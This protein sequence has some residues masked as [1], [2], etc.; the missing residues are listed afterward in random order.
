MSSLEAE[1]SQTT[2]KAILLLT[3]PGNLRNPETRAA[4][5]KG[6]AAGRE[7]NKGSVAQL[8]R[9]LHSSRLDPL[10]QLQAALSCPENLQYHRGGMRGVGGGTECHQLTV[11]HYHLP[12]VLQPCE[13]ESHLQAD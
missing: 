12:W 2:G 9:C 7:R 6:K 5:Q 11:L 8:T 13:W 10:R 1:V 3:S 4:S